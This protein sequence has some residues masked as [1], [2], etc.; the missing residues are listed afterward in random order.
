MSWLDGFR[1]RVRGL[2]RPV[3]H[4][5]ELREE[6]QLHED[7]DAM[8]LG[9]KSAARRHFGNRT[10]Y[11]EEVR[12]MTWLARLD[13]IRQDL[14][15]A[16]RSVRRSPGFTAMV[17]LALALGVGLNAATFSVIDQL[18]LRPPAGVAN[19][20]EVRRVWIESFRVAGRTSST[21]EA[22]NFPMFRAAAAA[23][24]D[25]SRFAAIALISDYRLGG[26]RAG[27][28]VDIVYATSNYFDV[29]GVQPSLG[30]F[31]TAAEDQIG[32]PRTVVVSH[33]MWRTQLGADST[34]IGRTI[35]L[36]TTRFTVL[37]VAPDGFMGI[38][39]DPAHLWA[40][41]RTYPQMEWLQGKLFESERMYIFRG[42]YRRA[43]GRSD[44]AFERLGSLRLR[45]LSREQWQVNPDT[46]LNVFT[47]PVL[48]A[49]GPGDQDQEFIITTR[50]GGVAII[51]L[52]IACA[53]VVNLLL[54][55]ATDRRREIAVRLALG[56]SRARLVRMLTTETVLLALL[57]ASAAM[58]TAWWGGTALRALLLPNVEW[59]GSAMHWRVIVFT[60]GIAV[61]AGAFAGLIPAV[62]FSNPRLTRAL[63]DGGEV[64]G[65]RRFTLRSGL[66]VTQ[67]ALSVMLV[68][69]AGLFVRS[70]HNVQEID[71]G[72]D[73]G[74]LLF[75]RV[76]FDPGRTP[77]IAV[78][79]EKVRAVQERLRG[80]PGV[81]GTALVSMEPMRGLSFKS[82][83]W[84]S[85]SSESIRKDFPS[86]MA[87][88]PEFFRTAGIRVVRGRLFDVGVAGNHQVIVNEAMAKQLW[89]GQEALGQCLRFGKREA[90]CHVVT[91]IVE[92][93]SQRGVIESPQPQYYLPVGSSEASQPA[94]ALVVRARAGGEAIATRQIASLLQQEFPD[95]YP[96]I[97][98]M[99]ENLESEYRPWK[100]GAAL[101]TG[102]GLLA[103][104]V[105]LVGIYSSISYSVSQRKREFG[106]RIALGAQMRDILNLVLSEGLRVVLI[107]IA[108]GIAFGLAA[109]K[110]ISALLFGV[111][112]NDPSTILM[113][114]SGLL[115]VAGLAALVPALRASRVD[116]A[117]SLR[118]D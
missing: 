31:F 57:A 35:L 18:Y 73:A 99:L 75:G 105:A 3:S 117:M 20:D 1:H 10:W 85:D 9:D 103:L 21:R 15:Y 108:V 74:Q 53:N 107:G 29:L 38:D 106:V 89:P 115:V 111:Q 24:G 81:E 13:T 48:Q 26:T 116:P 19:P 101:F 67:A 69:G 33:Q 42:F 41:M 88:T 12:R 17:V 27:P 50:L 70:L 32:A 59:T 68:A 80:R 93:V 96:T 56:I 36:D 46:L 6:M 34:I 76:A 22:V 87:V 118:A 71:I 39:I 90:P 25:T 86:Y 83:Y 2:L 94:M 7:L 60:L 54:A 30:R 62:Q 112:P 55:R 110:L 104:A 28:L 64:R 84:G 66:L 40:P 92:T 95:G 98:P 23:Y 43:A 65:R 91:A 5:E 102:F 49:R 45:E 78:R 113:V 52:L 109:G 16:W 79:A 100:L 11:Q 37:G 58:L 63:K 97:T 77:P 61:A 14:G 114:S 51:V 82:F 72:Y 8:Q 4:E 47:G 44:D